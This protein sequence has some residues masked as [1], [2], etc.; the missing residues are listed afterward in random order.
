MSATH[1][2]IIAY[3]EA[4]KA[5]TAVHRC[6]VTVAGHEVSHTRELGLTPEDAWVAA[7][8]G[9]LNVGRELL[10]TETA[11]LALTHAGAVTGKVEPGTH[12]LVVDGAV[13]P[14]GAPAIERVD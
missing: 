8:T 3:N 9:V 13:A 10:E 2:L 11:R 12:R 4:T 1:K 14:G 5:L 6:T 7:L